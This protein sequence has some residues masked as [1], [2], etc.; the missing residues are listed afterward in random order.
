MGNGDH[1][2]NELKH[3]LDKLNTTF[4]DSLRHWR[5]VKEYYINNLSILKLTYSPDEAHR[6]MKR[7]ALD[8]VCI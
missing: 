5:D 1:F 7:R 6:E 8:M 3:D 2:F 4:F